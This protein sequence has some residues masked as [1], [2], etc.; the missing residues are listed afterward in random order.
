MTNT[1]IGRNVWDS[2]GTGI[3]G[4]VEYIKEGWVG[5]RAEDGRLDEIPAERATDDETD[6]PLVAAE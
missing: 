4:T 2:L 6:L 5:I 3:S 1:A